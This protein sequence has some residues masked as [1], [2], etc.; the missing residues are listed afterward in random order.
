MSSSS[1]MISDQGL[2]RALA[3]YFRKY[4]TAL[5][6]FLAVSYPVTIG[7]ILPMYDAH[8]DLFPKLTS[9]ACLI[10]FALGSSAGVLCWHRK[11]V[12]F[13]MGLR[14]RSRAVLLPTAFACLGCGVAAIV[15]YL[16][17]FDASSTIRRAEI[18]SATASDR[19]EFAS[20]TA[21]EIQ[22]A[23]TLKQRL[24]IAQD[25]LARWQDLPSNQHPEMADSTADIPYLSLIHI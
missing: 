7:K 18:V 22:R 12:R 8:R 25:F 9:V 19:S 24:E 2:V 20:E 11:T 23:P 5:G 15:G 17:L 10:A 21:R 14:F 4:L 16:L 1:L 3:D 6:I 13:G